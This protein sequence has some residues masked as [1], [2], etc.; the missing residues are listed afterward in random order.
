MTNRKRIY[1]EEAVYFVTSNT[2]DRKPYFSDTDLA[3]ILQEQFYHYEDAY[4]YS[5][6]AYAIMPDHYHLL[7][8]VEGEENISQI[9]H[10]INSYS[11]TEIN[12]NLDNKPKEKVWQGDPWT[13]VIRNE[14]MFRQKLAYVLLNPWREGLVDRPQ[15][16][17]EFSNLVRWKEDEGEKFLQ[18][19]FSQYGR[20]WE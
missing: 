8:T 7:L 1:R 18:D 15:D 16:S 5:I 3:E 19:L 17:Y 9:I 10:A 20:A 12:K 6:H 14:D 11:A 2:K 4:D 13:E